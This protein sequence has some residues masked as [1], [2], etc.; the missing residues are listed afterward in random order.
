MFSHAANQR[1]A[2]DSLV[3]SAKQEINDI[4]SNING[5][6]FVMLCS[7]DGFELATVNKK[8]V[9]NSGKLAA[10]SSSIL[11]MVTAFISEI[12]LSGCQTITL[13]AE[14]GKAILTSVPAKNHP[15]IIVTMASR[16]VLLG[17][18]LHAMKKASE[19]IVYEDAKLSK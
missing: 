12:R 5:V 8:T 7:T 15:M 3:N 2:P 17:Q 14:N 4:L 11:A 6:D 10:V 19:N 13:D 1:K 16:D 9:P 18:L